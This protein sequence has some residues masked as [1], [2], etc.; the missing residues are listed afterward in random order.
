MDFRFTPEEEAFRQDVRE[1]L[2]KEVPREVLENY[3]GYEGYEIDREFQKKLATRGW[4]TLAWPKEYGGRGATY[5]E[6]LIFA[7]ELAYF[8]APGGPGI[9]QTIV[10]PMLMLVGNEK[11]KQQWLP[12]IASGEIEFGLGYTEPGAGSDLAS[13]QIR[14]EE[15]G[16]FFVINGHKIFQTRQ[17]VADYVW[18][19]ARTDPNAPK[20]RGI[21]LFIVDLKSPGISIAPMWTL[22][23]GRTNAVYYDN[24]RVP[25]ENFVG[26]KNM[27]WYHLAQAL[28]FE[29]SGIG[30][31]AIAQR[32]FDQLVAYCKETGLG[33][34]PT[35]RQRLGHLAAEIDAGRLMAYRV[36]WQQQQGNYNMPYE[37]SMSWLWTGYQ[38]QHVADIGM[39][40]LGL[41]AQ[42]KQG[43]QGAAL[44]GRLEWLYRETLRWSIGGGT[45]QIQKNI[46][47]QR[48]L[49]LPRGS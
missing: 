43:S 39:K 33:K 15:Q 13:L 7:E 10:G 2:K 9:A 30:R 14:A 49:G 19:A 11:Q 4:L 29:R 26:E 38:A 3:E 34:E 35:V 46:I 27:G 23:G 42:L 1:F 21:S 24:V 16:D 28:Q 44:M 37:A 6:Q 8:G 45:R 5:I 48:G 47:A 32:I 12:K 20:H 31:L 36:A 40:I 18:L 25:K 22:G 17:H 41:R